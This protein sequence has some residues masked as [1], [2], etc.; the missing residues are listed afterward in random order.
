MIKTQAIVEN[1]G[2]VMLGG[3]FESQETRADDKV[4][5]LGDIPYVGNLFKSKSTDIKKTEMLIF[6]TPRIVIDGNIG[7]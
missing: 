4:P 2:T 3:I 1:G 6:I 5:L 7:N